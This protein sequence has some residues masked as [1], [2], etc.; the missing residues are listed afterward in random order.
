[1]RF[2]PGSLPPGR[3][4]TQAGSHYPGGRNQRAATWV[5][6][7]AWRRER[8]TRRQTRDESL[9]ISAVEERPLA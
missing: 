4:Q 8:A 1:M 2:L 3:A 9:L 5:I 7:Y 6:R